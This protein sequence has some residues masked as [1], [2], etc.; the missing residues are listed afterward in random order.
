MASIH[1]AVP[2]DL[3]SVYMLLM[4]VTFD[5]VCRKERFKKNKHLLYTRTV[6]KIKAIFCSIKRFIFIVGKKGLLQH[7]TILVLLFIYFI[8]NDLELNKVPELVTDRIKDQN[9]SMGPIHGSAG[10]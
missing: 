2:A 9:Y 6:L 4:K 3:S 5:I 7:R 8:T 10:G 1:D